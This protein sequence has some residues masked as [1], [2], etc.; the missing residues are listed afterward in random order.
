[1]IQEPEPCL[2]RNCHKVVDP[3]N[4]RGLCSSCYRT[5]KRLVKS[6][7]TT[8]EMLERA[9]F[10]LKKRNP[11]AEAF[12]RLEAPTKVDI[13]PPKEEEHASDQPTGTT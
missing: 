10:V 6:S 11:F 12:A 8:W 9:G 3:K 4:E 7:H 5:A 13:S 2:T 1:M